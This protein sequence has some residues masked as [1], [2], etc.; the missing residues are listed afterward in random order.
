M[1]ADRR[2]VPEKHISSL[3]EDEHIWQRSK[4]VKH[5]LIRSPKIIDKVAERWVDNSGINCLTRV[6]LNNYKKIPRTAQK[7]K[8]KPLIE[9][10]HAIIP[11]IS[12]L[13]VV[14]H[15]ST[16]VNHEV[17]HS[18]DSHNHGPHGIHHATE[19]DI[20]TNHHIAHENQHQ[21]QEHWDNNHGHHHTHWE[22]YKSHEHHHGA[23]MTPCRSFFYLCQFRTLVWWAMSSNFCYDRTSHWWNHWICHQGSHSGDSLLT[24]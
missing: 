15:S 12:T 23:F 2:I 22:H 17:K 1:N 3:L 7:I 14:H 19:V 21:T 6:L 10:N 20:H 11:V 9:K 8:E 18:D 5:A 16:Q 13:P 4:A 24:H